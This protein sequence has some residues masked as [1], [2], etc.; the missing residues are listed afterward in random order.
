M[1]FREV[2]NA[3]QIVREY[4]RGKTDCSQCRLHTK[5]D[6]KTCGV[7]ADGTLPSSWEFDLDPEE[8]VPSVF[9]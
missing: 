9:K 4:C 3:L 8:S 7:A 6:D 5:K 2:V 1:D